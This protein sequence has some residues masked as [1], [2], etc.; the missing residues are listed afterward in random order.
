LQAGGC[1]Y[2]VAPGG[3]RELL[4]RAWDIHLLPIY[5]RLSHGEVPGRTR[6][7]VLRRPSS[8][9]VDATQSHSPARCS[10][11]VGLQLASGTEKQ[12]EG[13]GALTTQEFQWLPLSWAGLLA[14]I[15][16]HNHTSL[17]PCSIPCLGQVGTNQPQCLVLGPQ[18]PEL[19]GLGGSS[20]RWK[21]LTTGVVHSD[22]QPGRVR[23]FFH[24]R[25][26]PVLTSSRLVPAVKRQT[27]YHRQ[28]QTS[29]IHCPR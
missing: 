8:R 12:E 27:T 1:T 23:N 4:C 24:L 17:A 19:L 16:S 5:R 9:L 25:P 11:D 13:R 26:D 18:S 14:S 6:D 29:K 2:C 22:G 15:P 7:L 28:L 10:S 20:G 21:V 3:G